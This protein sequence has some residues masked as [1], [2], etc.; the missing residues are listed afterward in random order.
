MKHL[1]DMFHCD[2]QTKENLRPVGNDAPLTSTNKTKQRQPGEKSKDEV[3][4]LL[5]E[6]RKRLG[7][8]PGQMA[9]LKDN[10]SWLDQVEQPWQKWTPEEKEKAFQEFRERAGIIP[11]KKQVTEVTTSLVTPI[12]DTR[13]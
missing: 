9:V 12:T 2:S 6:H 13:D 8:I 5:A 10:S 4:Q 11:T 7:I 3:E 1:G